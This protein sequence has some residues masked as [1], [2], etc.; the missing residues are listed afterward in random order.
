MVPA[1]ARCF[2]TTAGGSCTLTMRLDPPAAYR[3]YIAASRAEL[4]CPKAIFRELRTGWFSDRSAC[5]LASGRPVVA[6]D[7]GL[8]DHY[9]TGSGLLC[10]GNLDE[11]VAGVAAIDAD[12]E[13]HSRAARDFAEE[14]LDSRRALPAMLAACS[15]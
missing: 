6:E 12:Y 9:P 4:A 8:S 11:A 1:I 2:A 13:R 10:F 15:A 3:N 5:Y 14:F 7:T